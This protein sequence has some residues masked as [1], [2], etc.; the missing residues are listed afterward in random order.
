MNGPWIKASVI[1]Y[2]YRKNEKPGVLI[3]IGKQESNSHACNRK[4]E[5]VIRLEFCPHL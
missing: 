1:K 5:A 2:V 3:F 4:P